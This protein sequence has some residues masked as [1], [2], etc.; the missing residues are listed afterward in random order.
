MKRTLAVAATL[1]FT[2]PAVCAQLI[3]YSF[4][5]AAGNEL[6]LPPDAQP[7]HAVAS[8][9]S[10]GPGLAPSASADTFSA[11]GFTTG[12]VLDPSDYYTF[13]VTPNPGYEMTLTGLE[14]D[15]RR[16]GTG[17]RNWLIRSSLDGFSLDLQVFSVPDDTATRVNQGLVL[18]P[19]FA[20]LAGP[21]EFRLYGFGAESLSGTWRIDNLEV[22]GSITPVPEP[23]TCALMFGAGLLGFAWWRRCGS[24]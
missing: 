22:A 19:S 12:G 4:T 2:C 5:G 7:A 9:M 3:V 18:G 16:S 6:L 11:S 21:V 14:L 1:A 15:E 8:P 24:A 23:G 20:A 13:T 17:I 10:R